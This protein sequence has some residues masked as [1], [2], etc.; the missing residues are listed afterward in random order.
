MDIV[1]ASAIDDQ[2]SDSPAR[3]TITSH[4]RKQGTEYDAA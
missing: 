1:L 3:D 2:R 4:A